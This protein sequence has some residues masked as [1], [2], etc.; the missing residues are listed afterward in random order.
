MA[1]MVLAVEWS[2]ARLRVGLEFAMKVTLCGALAVTLVMCVMIMAVHVWDM[3]STTWRRWKMRRSAIYVPE[4]PMPT[5]TPS[6]PF[7]PTPTATKERRRPIA[8]RRGGRRRWCMHARRATLLH[9]PTLPNDCAFECVLLCAGQRPTKSAIDRLRVETATRVKEAYVNDDIIAGARVREVVSS[10]HLT[11]EAYTTRLKHDMWASMVEVIIALDIVGASAFLSMSKGTPITRW[12]KQPHH[13]IQLRHK[14]YVLHKCHRSPR[15]RQCASLRPDKTHVQH[16]CRGGH[17]GLN[18][19]I[20]MHGAFKSVQEVDKEWKYAIDHGS[21]EYL[22]YNGEKDLEKKQKNGSHIKGVCYMDDS[23]VMSVGCVQGEHTCVNYLDCFE[24][25]EVVKEYV[26]RNSKDG[27]G[28]GMKMKK[29]NKS[30][31]EGENHLDV[32]Y[33]ESAGYDRELVNKCV[34]SME[35]A[36]DL[37][38]SYEKGKDCGYEKGNYVSDEGC[39]HDEYACDNYLEGTEEDEDVGKNETNEAEIG[40]KGSH[41]KGVCYMDDS[42]EMNEGCVHG[43][44]TCV[45]LECFEEDE[46][47][48]ESVYGNAK[49]GNGCAMRMKKENKRYMEGEKYLDDSYAESAGYDYELVKKCVRSMEGASDLEYSY[50]K[51]KDYVH[52][53]GN[54]VLDEGCVHDEHARDNYL[55]GTEEYEGVGKNETEVEIGY[56]VGEYG[57]YGEDELCLNDNHVV[58]EY[59]VHDEWLSDSYWTYLQ[60]IEKS[61]K[62]SEIGCAFVR[63]GMHHDQNMDTGD[64]WDRAW[65]RQID[66]DDTPPAWATQDMTD[67]QDADSPVAPSLQWATSLP[68]P[69]NSTVRVVISG[70]VRSDIKELTF[71]AEEV[72]S[73]GALKVRLMDIIMIRRERIAIYP[74]DDHTTKL[75][76]WE[77]TRAEVVVF[78]DMVFG[79]PS[80][81]YL[82][83]YMP[84]KN[85]EFILRI[86]DGMSQ[87]SIERR[88]GHI[89]DVEPARIQLTDHRGMEWRFPTSRPLTSAVVLNISRGGMH[90]ASRSRSR[91]PTRPPT[92]RTTAMTPTVPWSFG[93]H[94]PSGSTEEQATPPFQPPAHIRQSMDPAD[95][96][97]VEDAVPR[98][99]LAHESSREDALYQVGAIDLTP[100]RPPPSPTSVETDNP[101]F[102][103]SAAWPV[104]PPAA[105]PRRTSRPIRSADGI[106]GNAFAAEEASTSHVIQDLERAIQPRM[107]LWWTPQEARVWHEVLDVRINMPTPVRCVHGYDIR[108][109]IWEFYQEVRYIPVLSAGQP[110]CTVIASHCLSMTQVQQRISEESIVTRHWHLMAPTHRDWLILSFHLPMAVIERLDELDYRR[111]AEGL[112][113]LDE[114]ERGGMRNVPDRNMVTWCLA[115]NPTEVREYMVKE[116]MVVA[117]LVMHLAWLYSVDSDN[118]LVLCIDMIPDL[119]DDLEIYVEWSICGQSLSNVWRCLQRCREDRCLSTNSTTRLLKDP[120]KSLVLNTI[121]EG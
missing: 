23:Y 3:C 46:T 67:Q 77:A 13:I 48:K 76:D 107:P 29:E 119:E 70:S 111:Q 62:H 116:G 31:M 50:V 104:S 94:S 103:H 39:V 20:H 17:K 97:W 30:C 80:T 14:H 55:V 74:L 121:E 64:E 47:V 36:L 66:D 83:I 96:R 38:D 79:D 43:E 95:R 24:E 16:D 5:R 68:A 117:E 65:H 6:S 99:L 37:D 100:L 12:G 78:D 69:P 11:L 90:P 86:A 105:Q 75:N 15:P 44:H 120:H 101:N 84:E 9:N 63:G 21:N 54:Y 34:R 53:K 7:K 61:D 115:T 71:K 82:N 28:C 59:Y 1:L 51:G 91:S 87:D 60:K 88:I 81:D 52:E 35:G 113:P 27:V 25:D 40:K 32:G 19:W 108:R 112:P 89:I 45:Y 85:A 93:P 106:V 102:V 49:C 10:T 8:A 73:V 41:I 42:Y 2:P 98:G 58:T 26:Q 110:A 118:I 56:W 18:G 92:T 33:A 4:S 109:G 57:N 114:P 22:S 72:V